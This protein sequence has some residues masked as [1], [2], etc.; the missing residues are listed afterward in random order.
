MKCNLS[1]PW[2]FWN[3]AAQG[4]TPCLITKQ[5]KKKQNSPNAQGTVST[6][7]NGKKRKVSYISE[8]EGRCFFCP[9]L[10]VIVCPVKVLARVT[11]EGRNTYGFS[12]AGFQTT[13]SLDQYLKKII[14]NLSLEPKREV[15]T[16]F[17]ALS[18][19]DEEVEHLSGMCSMQG[20]EVG[21][22]SIIC[23]PGTWNPG[24]E[25]GTNRL[26]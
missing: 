26:P 12:W 10:L 7:S 25:G 17:T 11:C 3:R 13:V 2:W 18:F 23:L 4:G 6:T 15:F 9:M 8:A 16:S 19:L 21:V 22:L 1:N 14:G 5:E 24:K 20:R